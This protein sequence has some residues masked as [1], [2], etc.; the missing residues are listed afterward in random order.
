M[1][2]RENTS[3]AIQS[4][5]QA[6][7]LLEQFHLHAGEL[8]APEIVRLMKLKKDK[9]TRL[10][11]TLESRGYIERHHDT[12]HYRLGHKLLDLGQSL[13]KQMKLLNLSRPVI[14]SMA[15]ACNETTYVATL[16]NFHAMY[17][18]TVTCDHPVQVV[19]PLGTYLPAYC[20]AAGKVQIAG[21]A[22]EL[23]KSYLFTQEL[24]QYTPHTI[25]DRNNLTR[26]LQQIAQQGYATDNQ[27]MELGAYSVGAPIRDGTRRIV[28]AV[29]LSCPSER[30]SKQRMESEFIPLVTE[31][32]K[33]ISNEMGY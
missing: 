11:A 32:A 26:H 19:S 8:G 14:G 15:K 3:Y 20:T 24:R 9:T 16:K 25:T 5:C 1:T 23:L 10:L 29:T 33:A 18:E 12:E 4:V 28:G 2:K 30:F 27:E 31:G 21:T 7:D 17:L 6:L 13:S 22:D